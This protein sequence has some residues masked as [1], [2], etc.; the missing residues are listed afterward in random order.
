MVTEE[1]RSLETFSDLFYAAY[2][3]HPLAALWLSE[4]VRRTEDTCWICG[5]RRSG[6]FCPPEYKSF[7]SLV[8]HTVLACGHDTHLCTPCYFLKRFSQQPKSVPR[9]EKESLV[10][11]ARLYGRYRVID[12]WNGPQEYS[13]KHWALV[14]IGQGSW[15]WVL[16]AEG[17]ARLPTENSVDFLFGELPPPFQVAVGYI[18][19]TAWNRVLDGPLYFGG[20][21]I[22][23][24]LVGS[25]ATTVVSREDLIQAGLLIDQCQDTMHTRSLANWKP[26]RKHP[27][28]PQRTDFLSAARRNVAWRLGGN[29]WAQAVTQLSRPSSPALDSQAVE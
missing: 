14:P 15:R 28:P 26:S 6:Y 17:W 23:V 19:N 11:Q 5:R 16:S 29:S 20:R 22:P 2:G 7:T 25:N 13:L 1:A 24:F 3:D 27:D 18:T 10:A 12:G 21:H 8:E 4:G 9:D